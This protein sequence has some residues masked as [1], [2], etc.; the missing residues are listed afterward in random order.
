MKDWK[1]NLQMFAEA[2]TLVNAFPG[3]TNAYTGEVTEFVPG[4]TDLSTLNK[5]FTDTEAF[6]KIMY[7]KAVAV[8][9]KEKLLSVKM[10]K[11]INICKRLCNA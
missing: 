9:G 10:F 11:C 3:Y 5:T 7:G 4:V 2:G 1:L 8:N 6:T